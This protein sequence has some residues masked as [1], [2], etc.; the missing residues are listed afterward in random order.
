M[1]SDTDTGQD[2]EYSAEFL[3]NGNSLENSEEEIQKLPQ[4]YEN[5]PETEAEP[6]SDDFPSILPAVKRKRSESTFDF[7]ISIYKK[8][9]RGQ[10]HDKGKVDS[11]VIA[12]E[13][14][15][16]GDSP[17]QV[18]E[19]IWGAVSS[20]IRREVI[21]YDDQNMKRVKWAND[22][23]P[24]FEDMDKYI[25]FKDLQRKRTYRTFDVRENTDI[26]VRWRGKLIDVYLHVY[27]LAVTNQKLYELV[28]KLEAPND[29]DRSGASS[30]KSFFGLINELK[31]M[32][33][34]V[35]ADSFVWTNW[36]E[37][38]EAAPGY[39]RDDVKLNPPN[40]VRS[41]LRPAPTDESAILEENRRGLFFAKTIVCAMESDIKVIKE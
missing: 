31:A 20:H 21:V 9:F 38:V 27:S 25:L 19:Q 26:M 3:D 16:F 36:A 8:D 41:H 17:E 28:K 23:D 22:A 7:M 4:F 34:E 33:P 12:K 32:H 15:V 29:P 37:H 13:W 30:N 18:F 14:H 1:D 2:S 5:C 39:R 10:H 11:K 40:S 6:Q 24:E 35:S